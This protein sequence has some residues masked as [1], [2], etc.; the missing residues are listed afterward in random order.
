MTPPQKESKVLC[1]CLGI[2]EK[3]VAEA[4]EDRALTTV[5][6]VAA[7]TEAGSGCTVCHPAIRE[8][9]QRAA[10]ARAAAKAPAGAPG[11]GASGCVD[12]VRA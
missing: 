1:E 10:R 4:I 2:T 3:T 9:L 7:C 8:Y 5:K 6:Q 12:S 11:P